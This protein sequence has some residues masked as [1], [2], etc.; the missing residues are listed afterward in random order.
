M[1]KPDEI[2]LYAFM[3]H[4]ARAIPGVCIAYTELAARALG[5]PL[6]RARY[7]VE[8]WKDQNYCDGSGQRC[9]YFYTTAPSALLPWGVVQ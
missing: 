9:V 5:I 3:R 1:K 6:P 2:A 4:E 8:K 7:L